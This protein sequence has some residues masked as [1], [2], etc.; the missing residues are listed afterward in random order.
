M[1][2]SDLDSVSDIEQQVSPHP[3]TRNQFADSLASS[4]HCWVLEINTQVAGFFLYSL[5]SGEAEVLD[6]AVK[7]KFQGKGYGRLLLEHLVTLAEKR[8]D[9]LFLE[10]RVSNVAAI[11]LYMNADFNQVGERRNYYKMAHGREDA[12]IFAKV[13]TNPFF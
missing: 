5:A 7:P 6:I 8:A 9:T 13:L 2:E 12:L 10:V 11:T 4:H 1:L 3:W